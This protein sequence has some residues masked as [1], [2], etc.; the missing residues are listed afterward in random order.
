MTEIPEGPAVSETKWCVDATPAVSI[1]MP[2]YNGERYIEKALGSLLAQTFTNFEL[3]ISDNASSDATQ[4]ICE[5]YAARDPR[6]VYIRQNENL[7]ASA[8]FRH[9]LRRA[10]GKLFMW[11]AADDWWAENWLAV[12]TAE[13]SLGDFGVRGLAVMVDREGQL[14][15]TL[16]VKSFARGDVAR[17]F[18]DDEKNGRAFYFYGLLHTHLVLETLETASDSCMHYYGSDLLFAYL[19]VQ[20]G[21]LRVTD[22]TAQYYRRHDGNAGPKHTR[23]YL[24]LARLLYRAHPFCFYGSHWRNAPS[25]RRLVIALAIPVKYLKTQIELWLRGLYFLVSGRRVL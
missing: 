11:A 14:L 10:R 12:L 5:R 22:K 6:I 7:G 13:I 23:K 1:G 9:V 8:N 21:A 16:P 19:A 2:V 25:E 3:I 24:S 20:K 4:T 18:L 17:V 15:G